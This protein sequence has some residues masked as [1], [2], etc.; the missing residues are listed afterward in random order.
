MTISS[1]F[2]TFTTT[3]NGYAYDMLKRRNFDYFFV[4][5]VPNPVPR[6]SLL[7]VRYIFVTV[8]KAATKSLE[9]R[10]NL[11]GFC[12]CRT[13]WRNKCKFRKQARFIHPLRS[14]ILDI[15]SRFRQL[16]IVPVYKGM[17]ISVNSEFRLHLWSCWLCASISAICQCSLDE[18][19]PA[20]QYWT[21][22]CQM[23]APLL[24]RQ[25]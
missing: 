20:Q 13:I 21:H 14:F 1:S 10:M 19:R 18:S 17:S 7:A 4:P 11:R 15:N 6:L 22:N 16:P 3:K 25:V 12:F 5:I 23:F 8:A 9:I 2:P 24:C